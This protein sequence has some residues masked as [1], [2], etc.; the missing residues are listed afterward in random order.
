MKN[1]GVCCLNKKVW[2]MSYSLSVLLHVSFFFLWWGE[3]ASD[4]VSQTP[5][6]TEG[7]G[8]GNPFSRI[9]LVRVRSVSE[10][11]RVRPVV[12]I[13][14]LELVPPIQFEITDDNEVSSL[15]GD[16]SPDWARG[17]SNANLSIGDSYS[18]D[19]SDLKSPPLPRSIV[20][21]QILAGQGLGE[22]QIDVF[23]D[24]SGRVVSD[25]TRIFSPNAS[26]SVQSQLFDKA[27]EWM[28]DPARISGKPVGSWFSY[29][30]RM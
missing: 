11:T 13:V 10:N 5:T 15:I 28:F 14:E 2:L 16:I 23:V 30:I 8:G 29:T 4:A 12:P 22:I 24:E 1:P 7:L 9:Q 25:S 6:S 20:I 19:G 26:S 17:L 21:P 27:S 18:G 3:E